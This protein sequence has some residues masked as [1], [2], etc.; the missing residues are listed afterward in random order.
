MELSQ[1][2]LVNE[3][4]EP[5]GVIGKMEAHER[6]FLHRAFSIFI[7]NSKGELLLQQRALNK[8]HSAGLWTN[9]CCSHPQPGEETLAVAH[10]RLQEEMGFT[11]ALEKVFDFIYKADVDNEL[12]EFELDHVFAGHYDGPVE[13][14]REEVMNVQY[15]SMAELKRSIQENPFMYTIWF[16]LAFPNIEDWWKTR[17]KHI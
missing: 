10:R 17:Y 16:R 3:R 2:I 7:F 1:V 9:T 15:K 14:N 6:G 4:D 12:T 5:T 11:T 8:Y 13:Y